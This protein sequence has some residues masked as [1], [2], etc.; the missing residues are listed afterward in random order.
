MFYV[1]KNHNLV[2]DNND[3]AIDMPI[4]INLKKLI[5][6]GTFYDDEESSFGLHFDFGLEDSYEFSFAFEK[7]YKYFQSLSSSSCLFD[8][9]SIL[10]NIENY[11]EP[12]ISKKR[13]VLTDSNNLEFIKQNPDLPIG[14]KILFSIENI[15]LVKPN[16]NGKDSEL[17]TFGNNSYDVQES[18][19][20]IYNLF[21]STSCYSL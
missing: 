10:K 13:I 16:E 2:F 5:S 21:F 8:I 18:T 17:F 7:K 6:L 9:D 11:E 14:K 4:L 15:L 19:Q 1:F 12:I 3:Q 20:E